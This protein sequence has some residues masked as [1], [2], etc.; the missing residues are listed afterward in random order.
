M[1]FAEASLSQ[2]PVDQ[3][4]IQSQCTCKVTPTAAEP[5][6]PRS[7]QQSHQSAPLCPPG[8]SRTPHNH[9]FPAGLIEISTVDRG[10]IS[11]RGVRSELYVAMNGRGRLYGTVRARAC[12]DIPPPAGRDAVETDPLVERRVRNRMMMMQRFESHHTE[13]EAMPRG[14]RPRTYVIR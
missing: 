5:R 10:V 9:V 7:P 13:Q 12:C 6:S 3:R 2:Q 8:G 1:R 14:G 11:L 4:L